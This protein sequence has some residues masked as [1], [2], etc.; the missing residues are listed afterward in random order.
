MTNAIKFI[1]LALFAS[2]IAACQVNKNNPNDPYEKFNRHSFNINMALDKVILK[3][4]AKFYTYV[5]PAPV[6]GRVSDFYQNI[7]TVPTIANDILQAK[8]DFAIADSTRLVLNSTL[9]VFGL[10]DIAARLGLPKHHEDFGLT[11]AAWGKGRQSYYLMVP[12]LGPSTFR[13][14]FALPFNRYMSIYPYLKPRSL[15][16]WLFAG[17]II[18]T[19]AQLLPADKMLATAFDPYVF[20]RDAYLQRRRHEIE[21]NHGSYHDYRLAHSVA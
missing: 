10:F 15:A 20:M 6:Q 5:V 18:N 9:G 17:S 11:L 1:S 16:H 7:D 3:P 19:R 13:D 14:T 4:A 21:D 12:V 8:F 2:V